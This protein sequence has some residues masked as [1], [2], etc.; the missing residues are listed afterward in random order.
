VRQ[1]AHKDARDADDA[2]HSLGKVGMAVKYTV[3]E[4]KKKSDQL[5]RISTTIPI[6][7]STGW[8][9]LHCKNLTHLQRCRPIKDL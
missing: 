8:I 7:I 1:C 9:V 3:P 6:S 5:A 4:T 2:R